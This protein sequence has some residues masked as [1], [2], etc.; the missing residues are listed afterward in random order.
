MRVAGL[1]PLIFIMNKEDSDLWYTSDYWWPKRF[2]MTYTMCETIL[3]DFLGTF[4]WFILTSS[5][6]TFRSKQ[7]QRKFSTFVTEKLAK[8]VDIDTVAALVIDTF[9]SYSWCLSEVVRI[10][11]F[12]GC[13][14]LFF[15]WIWIKCE[16]NI[17]I[18]KPT[19]RGGNWIK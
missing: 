1:P 17:I 13:L 11:N 16:Y 14:S 7:L 10:E 5:H 9:L 15:I 18:R 2:T 4:H 8:L 3:A 19:F 6:K 12:S